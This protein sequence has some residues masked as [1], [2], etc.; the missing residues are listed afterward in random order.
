V[1]CQKRLFNQQGVK[2]IHP[3]KVS[4]MRQ[5]SRTVLI[6]WLTL[7]AGCSQTPTTLPYPLQ[8]NDEGIGPLKHNTPF[9]ASMINSL[10]PGFDVRKFT[11]FE[12]GNAVTVLRVTRGSQEVF[13]IHPDQANQYIGLIKVTHPDITLSGM[14]L[15]GT[16]VQA[17][18]SMVKS[19]IEDDQT[20]R[21]QSVLFENVQLQADTQNGRF[22]AFVWKPYARN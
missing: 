14:A 20:L 18:D 6:L 10:L 9:N 19:C 21:C 13:I 3:R 8:V 17:A 1:P 15:I 22:T 7:L 5:V 4:A 2:S 12:A 16:P 11:A